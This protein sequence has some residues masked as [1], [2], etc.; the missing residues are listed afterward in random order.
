MYLNECP[1]CSAKI[2]TKYIKVKVKGDPIIRCRHEF[3][4]TCKHTAKEYRQA[5]DDF[6]RDME[7]MRGD[8]DLM[9]DDR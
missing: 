6:K 1:I 7:N 2:E 5:L 8:L 3:K 4:W 9:G